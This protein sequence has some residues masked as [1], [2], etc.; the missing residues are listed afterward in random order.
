MYS[1]KERFNRLFAGEPVDRAP[2]VNLLGI[3]GSCLVRWKNEG[4][5]NDASM[6]DV[7]K[8][9]GFDSDGRRGH[10]LHV[11]GLIWPEYDEK[12]IKQVD[13]KIWFTNKMGGISINYT[14]QPF[15]PLVFEG[16]LKDRKKWE[17]IKERLVWDTPGRFPGHWDEAC[18]NAENSGEPIYTADLYYGFFGLPREL[19]GLEDLAC[20][21]YE[22]PELLHDIMDT[23]CELWV[24]LYTAFL[25]KAK[26]DY[27]IIWEDMC[28]K[29]G[30]LISPSFFREFML[31]RYK[32]LTEA[33]RGGGCKNIMVDSDGDVR[34]LLPLWIEGGVNI[35]FPFE[36]QFGLDITEIRKK[37]P[38]LGMVGGINK[39]ALEGDR[40]DIDNELKKVPFMLESGRYIPG[41]DHGITHDVSWDNFRYFFDRLRELIWKYKPN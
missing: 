22:D 27:Y 4:L 23:L 10:Y 18:K 8:I 7:Y 29:N 3:W 26:L 5:S 36:T 24:N 40:R 2:F 31:P 28:D 15:I 19:L 30:P 32:R 6:D 38:S 39:L 33:L 16:A 34:E 1:N 11:N 35:M 20:L 13:N 25:K 41:L 12:I 17:E 21:F 37:Y 9:A 14:D